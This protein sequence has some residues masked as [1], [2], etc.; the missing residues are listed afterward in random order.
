MA[1]KDS[2]GMQQPRDKDFFTVFPTNEEVAPAIPTILADPPA[3]TPALPLVQAAPI[4][5]NQLSSHT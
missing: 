4:D 1:R 2:S 5:V 3:P